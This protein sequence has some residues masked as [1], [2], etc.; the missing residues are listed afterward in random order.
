MIRVLIADD[1]ALVRDGLRHILQNASS[2][3][4]VGEAQ[5]SASTIALMRDTEANVLVLSLIH[6]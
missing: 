2:F 6:I 1:H 3:E 4:V 5:D